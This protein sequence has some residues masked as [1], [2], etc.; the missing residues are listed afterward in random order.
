MLITALAV[1]I[2]LDG[3]II[4]IFSSSFY[5]MLINLFVQVDKK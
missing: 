3:D 1:G 2:D 5:S 4:V